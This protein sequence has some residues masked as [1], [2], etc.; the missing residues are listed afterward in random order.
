MRIAV[1]AETDPSEPRVAASPETVKKFIALGATLAVEPGAG[2][3]SGIPDDDFKAA[4]ADCAIRGWQS[5]SVGYD[6]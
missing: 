4:G 6:N 3:K 5:D 1:A 2:I